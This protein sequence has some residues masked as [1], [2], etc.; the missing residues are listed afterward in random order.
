MISSLVMINNMPNKLC[1]L[2]PYNALLESQEIENRKREIASIASFSWHDTNDQAQIKTG[3]FA[4]YQGHTKLLE[5]QTHPQI[6]LDPV[7][8][9]RRQ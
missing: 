2:I 9:L 7:S 1:S 8:K 6:I 4:L 5:Q 3:S